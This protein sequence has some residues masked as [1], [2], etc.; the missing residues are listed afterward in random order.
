MKSSDMID[1]TRYE[2]LHCPVRQFCPLAFLCAKR[3]HDGRHL[4]PAIAEVGYHEMVWTDLTVRRRVYVVRRG[5]LVNKC[6]VNNGVEVPQAL[7][8]PGSVAG[9]PDIYVPYV[10]SDFY[11]FVGLVPGQLCDFDG[12]VVRSQIDALGVPE[13]QMVLSRISLNCTTSMY[14]QSLTF[15]H[16]R[17]REKV[18]SV[19]LRLESA[20]ARCAD[21]TGEVPIAHDDVAF[22]AGLERATA[23]RELKALAKEG[24]IGLGYRRIDVLPGLR[25]AY[26]GLIEA[27]LPFYGNDWSAV[28]A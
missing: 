15:A 12:E 4:L 7:F 8:A 9:I 17:A 18:V 19:L 23:S 21:F 26:G 2:A 22:L 28:S 25:A 3:L 20:F 16:P 1:R 6:F 13:A 27:S 11:F 24:L 10:A 5:L 14:G